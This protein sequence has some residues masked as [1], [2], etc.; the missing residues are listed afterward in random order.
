MATLAKNR[1]GLIY[2]VKFPNGRCYI[3]KTIQGL[4]VRQLYHMNLMKRGCKSKFYNAL[5]KYYNQERWSVLVDGVLESDLNFVEMGAIST[6]DSYLNGYN[7]TVGGN[8]GLRAKLT[9]EH[10]RKISKAL[11]G[12]A[13][14]D[15]TRKKL[16]PTF[17]KKGIIPKNKGMKMSDEYK[18][19][20]SE[21]TKEGMKNPIVRAKLKRKN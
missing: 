1:L 6:F 19:F 21:K 11:M 4:R 3:G 13:V 17:F 16:A 8:G 7:S 15:E 9:E 18:K 2:I 20:I 10:K 5:R 12:H 14:S